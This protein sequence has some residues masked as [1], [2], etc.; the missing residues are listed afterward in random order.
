[1]SAIL[2]PVDTFAEIVRANKDEGRTIGSIGLA[3]VAV[4]N[5][6]YVVSPPALVTAIVVRM[7]QDD[8]EYI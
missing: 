2:L 1:M 8:C 3:I 5:A 6:F 7:A 4:G